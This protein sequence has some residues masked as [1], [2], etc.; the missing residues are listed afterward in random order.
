[1]SNTPNKNFLEI[2]AREVRIV[3]D[4]GRKHL[5]HRGHSVIEISRD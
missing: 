2:N 1:M 3:L 5:S 4:L